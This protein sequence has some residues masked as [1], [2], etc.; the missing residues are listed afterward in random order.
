MAAA[1]QF[2]FM[3]LAVDVIDRWGPSN[4][5]RRQLQPKKTKE[6]IS[7][8]YS[9]KRRFTHPPLLTRRSALVLK[10]GVSYGWK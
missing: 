8:L 3:T 4:E 1:F 6:I 5:M 9:S 7:H 2:H 10:V